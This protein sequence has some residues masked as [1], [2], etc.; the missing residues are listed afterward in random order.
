MKK[1]YATKNDN[2]FIF[3][4]EEFAHFNV[5]RCKVG[6]RVLCLGNGEEDYLVEITQVSKK[7]ARGELVEVINNAKNPKVN[8]TI[9]QGLVKGEKLDL[10]VQKLTELGITEL[11][12]FESEF[13][14]A[15]ANNNK[16]ERL[17]KITKEACKQCG[18]NLPL[19]INTGIKFDEMINKL[20]N[21]DC[22][23][24]AN[25][26]STERVLQELDKN[27]RIA[28]I[29]GSEGGFSDAEIEKVYN[30][31]ALNFGLGSRILRAETASIACASI[32]GYL[33]GV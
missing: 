2:E 29:V 28:V 8:I 31:G 18:R 9:F 21:F 12:L 10:I 7:E 15:K 4:G 5:L 23:L 26:K 17:L 13:S 30:S 16:S 1:F 11:V 32:L 20:S 6:E 19:K 3:E 25:E 22:I 27:A 24:F 14:V 33:L